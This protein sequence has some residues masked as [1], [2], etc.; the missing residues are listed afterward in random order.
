MRY[1]DGV[2]RRRFLAQA[3]L[4][5]LPAQ[6]FTTAALTANAFAAEAAL[7]DHAARKGI[8]YG[9]AIL[10]SSLRD[11]S[12]RSAVL[13]E[14]GA[15]VPE[16]EMKWGVNEPSRGK[17]NYKISDAIVSFASDNGLRLRGHTAVWY[18]NMPAWAK[19]AL[20]QPGGMDLV[21]GRAR[22]VVGRYAGKV[23]EWDVVNEEIEPRDK[24]PGGRRNSPFYQAAGPGF[25]AECFRIAHEAD[26]AALLFY[27]DYGLEYWTDYEDARRR[28]TLELLASLKAANAPIHGFGMQCHMKVG[29]RFNEKIFRRFLAD[30]ASLGLRIS[31]TEFDIDDMRLTA[32]IPERDRLVAEDAQRFL[33]VALDE[34]AVKT[35]MTWGLSHRY[36]WLSRERP[37]ADKL[38][39]RGLPLDAD[40]ARTPMWHAMARAFDN[41]PAR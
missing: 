23:Y 39:T 31:L 8:V 28:A 9:A 29:N 17:T 27:N 11:D 38:P 40:M 3:G 35:V 7:K 18:V 15:I 32:D 37:R 25:I 26:P 1:L 24:L 33:D 4:G 41:A 20:A 16:F 36:F 12:F 10:G 19:A 14:C 13:R 34:R 21:Y 5:L 2:S 22:D 6:A 30:V